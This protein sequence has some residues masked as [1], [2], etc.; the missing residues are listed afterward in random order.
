M[1]KELIAILQKAYND[2]F[3]TSIIQ[4][5]IEQVKNTLKMSDGEYKNI[6]NNVRIATYLKKVKERSEKGDTFIGDLRKQYKINDDDKDIIESQKA[7]AAKLASKPLQPKDV[8]EIKPAPVQTESKHVDDVKPAAVPIKPKESTDVKPVNP[9]P[10]P[11]TSVNAQPSAS[12]GPLVLVADDNQVQLT[13]TKKLLEKNNY[14]CITADT[15]ETAMQMIM[16]KKPGIILCDINFG[17]GKQSGLDMF[18]EL[19][20][21]K[22]KIPFIIISAYFQK[23]FTEYARQIGVSDYLTKP[24]DPETLLAAIKKNIRPINTL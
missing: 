6:D 8:V 12:T 20:T 23:E 14:T 18:Y 24:F 19:K 4:Q 21:K 13:I 16:E 7:V 2:G 17:I 5:E 3:I 15:P 10:E 1:S 22:I 9:V 11:N